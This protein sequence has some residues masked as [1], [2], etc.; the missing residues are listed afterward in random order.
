M[1]RKKRQARIEGALAYIPL[2]QGYEAVIDAS[3]APLVAGI[4][5]CALVDKRNVYAV[6]KQGPAG[7]QRT[8]RM[9]RLLMGEPEGLEVDHRDGNGLNN[10]RDNLRAATKSQNQQNSRL[11]SQNTSGFKGVSWNKARRKWESNIVLNQVKTC[12]GRFATAE[13]A[14]AAYIEASA[15]LHGEYGRP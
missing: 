10:R 9:H 13:E 4:N 3:D 6:Y 8:V 2:T 5:W 7:G 15:R 11:S 12:L 14:S 1:A